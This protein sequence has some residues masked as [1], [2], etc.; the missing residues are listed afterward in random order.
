MNLSA[1]L[2][3]ITRTQAQQVNAER[4]REQIS[5]TQVDLSAKRR[6]L[7]NQEARR[8]NFLDRFIDAPKYGRQSQPPDDAP[9]R[10][11]T[12][13]DRQEAANMQKGIDALRREIK[14]LEDLAN[15]ANQKL[16]THTAEQQAVTASFDELLELQVVLDKLGAEERAI[17]EA[18][19]KHEAA[20]LKPDA[21]QLNTTQAQLNKAL[22][23]A[24][25]GTVKQA[26]VD[27]LR[28]QLSRVRDEYRAAS[29]A[30]EQSSSVLEGLES[31]LE[32]TQQQYLRVREQYAQ[33]AQQVFRGLAIE[34]AKRYQAAAQQVADSLAR[35]QAITRLPHAPNNPFIW[36][37]PEFELPA[38]QEPYQDGPQGIGSKLIE[39]GPRFT[40][41]IDAAIKQL[42]AELEQAGIQL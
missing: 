4:L 23:G 37:F 2:K 1:V 15:A 14:A 22:A 36:K 9:G 3:K 31:R 35:L 19:Q 20:A 21:G 5:Q 33:T 7:A 29:D 38:L 30:H 39:S 26:E 28:T 34:E 10:K 17:I 32:E 11:M 41:R 25:L 13:L 6:E 16:N 27:K 40:P 8:R 12:D 42:H 24:A 18:R